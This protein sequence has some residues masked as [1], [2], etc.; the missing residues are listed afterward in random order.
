MF[1]ICQ[2]LGWM[3]VPLLAEVVSATCAALIQRICLVA[4]A[5]SCVHTNDAPGCAC[6]QTA[7]LKEVLVVL[8]CKQLYT[9]DSPG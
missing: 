1:G 2:N 9:K 4:F 5:S 8:A 6:I 3:Y 7:P